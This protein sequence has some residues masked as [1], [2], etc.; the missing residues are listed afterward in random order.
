MWCSPPSPHSHPDTPS[1]TS[2]HSSMRHRRIFDIIEF[3][4]KSAI[5]LQLRSSLMYFRNWMQK[6]LSCKSWKI[7]LIAE[8]FLRQPSRSLYLIYELWLIKKCFFEKTSTN[9]LVTIWN[10]KIID[11]WILSYINEM[12]DFRMSKC[13]NVFVFR[14]QIVH[15]HYTHQHIAQ[16]VIDE[17]S[18][19]LNS[20]VNLL[21]SYNWDLHWNISETECKSY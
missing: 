18:I 5:E 4:C 10:V 17:C 16:C 7:D 11:L 20:F 21:L 12:R 9:A 13:R 1:H 2:A 8:S 14:T 19:F 6:L 15:H 3:M